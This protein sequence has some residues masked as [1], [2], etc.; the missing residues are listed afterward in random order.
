[1]REEIDEEISL[2][3]YIRVL[4]KRK[5]TIFTVTITAIIAVLIANFFM[6]PVYKAS[7]TVLLSKSS[8]P[9][10]IFGSAEGNI[11][12]GQ[13]DEI[14]TQIEILKSYSIAKGVAEKLPA[15]IFEKTQAQNF[16]KKKDAFK[17]SINILDK[18][19]LKPFI[20]SLLGIN[21]GKNNDEEK[22]NFDKIVKQIKGSISVIAVKN[23][24]I[25]EISSENINPQLAAQIANTTANLF[26]EKSR[27]LN[28]SR[29]TEAK[30]FI[31]EQLLEKEKELGKGEE[32]K[33]QYKQQE[34]ILYLD[35]ETKINIEQLANFQAQEA[36]VAN[37]IAENKAKL[38]EAH[39]QLERQSETH[40][41][42][43][44]I[45]TNPI[46][47]QLQSQL[48]SLEI[49]LPTLL[50][51][52][53]KG[54][55][56]V[57]EVEIKIKETKNKISEKV[58][59]I[60]A[61]KVSARNPIYQNLLAEIVTLETNTISLDT[62]IEAISKTIKEYEK[63]LEKLPEKELQLARLER[64]V[65]VSENIYLTLLEE[66][67]E[68]RINEAMELGDIRVIDEAHVPGSPIKPNKKLN[69]AIGGILG[70]MLGVMLVFFLEY[71]DNT[72]K[73]TE[74][75]ERTLDLPI[76][77]VIPKVTQKSKRKRAY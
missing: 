41:S 48:V 7:T 76:L 37:L 10:A 55:P 24:N 71:M 70:L 58:A 13:A 5:W 62:K 4:R 57:T 31:E 49:Q 47:Q 74:D 39:K 64:A 25:I 67:Q 28:R 3:D 30:K 19:G 6:S 8:S 17:W 38:A 66:Y 50:E 72:I 34:N 11:L 22:P 54:S 73:T 77:G 16:Q 29:A 68:A 69:L 51:K 1:M 32:E 65:M 63:R 43:E 35:E 12:L 15:D 44:T 36:E 20:T 53:T 40:I 21:N 18:I 61:S 27:D 42:S 9:Q 75:V 23:T 46:V 45:T 33:L 59:E 2:Q 60:V 26:V 52:Y 56:Q 14:E